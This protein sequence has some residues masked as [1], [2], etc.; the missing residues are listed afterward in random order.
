MFTLKIHV[1]KL[2]VVSSRVLKLFTLSN[3][4]EKLEQE[5]PPV[6]HKAKAKPAARVISADSDHGD[7]KTDS[8]DS[9][10]HSSEKNNH[11]GNSVNRNST[12]T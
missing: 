5:F 11:D 4:K 6:N 12:I 8:I 10:K 7:S 1:R 2:K 3:V 9:T